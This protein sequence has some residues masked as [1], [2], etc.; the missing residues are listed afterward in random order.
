[1]SGECQFINWSRWC[2]ISLNKSAE[3]TR[4]SCHR[5]TC[6]NSRWLAYFVCFSYAIKPIRDPSSRP[7]LN[8]IVVSCHRFREERRPLQICEFFFPGNKALRRHP[9]IFSNFRNF[10]H[11]TWFLQQQQSHCYLLSGHTHTLPTALPGPP[12]WFVMNNLQ[13]LFVTQPP[14]RVR[15]IAMSM[16]VCLS[17]RSHISQ[18]T[19][20]N[21]TKFYVHVNHTVTTCQR[22]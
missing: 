20:P 7:R 2:I 14:I 4:Q 8:V 21:F 15:S 11:T 18:T 13:W 6:D 22:S 1:M 19:C 10:A 3:P 17:V 16:S 9:P 12:K 5:T